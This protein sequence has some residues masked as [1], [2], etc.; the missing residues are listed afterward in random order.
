MENL[1]S[2]QE[3]LALLEE[4]KISEEQYNELLE[5]MRKR[6]PSD[7]QRRSNIARR[8]LLWGGA[9][10]VVII[11][12]ALL[13]P[14]AISLKVKEHECLT[15]S[16]AYW[17]HSDQRP[18]SIPDDT[19]PQDDDGHMLFHVDEWFEEMGTAE[20]YRSF[21]NQADGRFML[22]ASGHPDVQ[23][24][25]ERGC[26]SREFYV[27]IPKSEYVRMEAGVRYTIEPVNSSPKYQWKVA[28][29]VTICTAS[30]E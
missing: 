25:A 6:P 14:R 5:A 28:P 21:L 9:S 8:Y 1:S 13:L 20:Q 12:G 30:K 23:A 2:E 26:W 16:K 3:L 17:F 19:V 18:S 24:N 10:V 11:A 29:G 22:K 4:G 27:R 15:I 7:S